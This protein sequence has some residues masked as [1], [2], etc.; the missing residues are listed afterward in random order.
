[1]SGELVQQA[2]IMKYFPDFDPGITKDEM[3]ASRVLL[4]EHA[5][6]AEDQ[7]VIA[8][9]KAL[10]EGRKLVSLSDALRSGGT[11]RDHMPKLAVLRADLGLAR[12]ASYPNG[13][14]RFLDGRP[15]VK[16]KQLRREHGH[17][18]RWSLEFQRTMEEWTWSRDYGADAPPAR[19]GFARAPYIPAHL[20]PENLQNYLVFWEAEWSVDPVPKPRPRVV[21]DPAILEQVVGDLYMVT[22][23]WDLTP[24]ES[25]ALGH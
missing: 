15:G 9:Y 11:D 23:T 22:A 10:E 25:A 20:R 7:R 16:R 5:K 2:A 24:I 4:E 13:T 14:V 3:T 21:I 12:G 8:A 1:M 18:E 6:S 17:T 19:T